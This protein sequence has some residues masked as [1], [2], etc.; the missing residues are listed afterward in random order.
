MLEIPRLKAVWKALTKK[1]SL[2]KTTTP[3]ELKAKTPNDCPYCGKGE[4]K[5][6]IPPPDPTLIPYNQTKSKRGRK[7]KICTQG[8]SCP[9]PDCYFYHVTDERIHAL[10][11]YGSH[12]KHERIPDLYCQACKVKFTTRMWTVLYR[13]KTLSKIIILSLS[14]LVLGMD[15]SALQEA[16]GI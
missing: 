6:S 8:Y 5:E 11:G 15:A 4:H 10:I 7:K 1:R 16:L 13:L 2:A 9:N 14:L 12:G 3:R